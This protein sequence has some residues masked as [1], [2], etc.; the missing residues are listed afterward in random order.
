MLKFL[1]KKTSL[2]RLDVILFVHEYSEMISEMWVG[3]GI[4]LNIES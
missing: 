1:E 3:S 4:G 2:D